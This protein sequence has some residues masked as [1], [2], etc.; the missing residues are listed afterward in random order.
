[1]FQAIEGGGEVDLLARMEQRRNNTA[2]YLW[3][4]VT[5][6]L[7]LFNET[8]LKDMLVLTYITVIF[9]PFLSVY[10]DN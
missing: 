4:N 9:D 7:N 6:T 10:E 8:A 2:Q 1:M 5:L 3:E